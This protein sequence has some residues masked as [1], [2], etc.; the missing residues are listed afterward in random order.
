MMRKVI[1]G[2]VVSRN[3]SPGLMSVMALMPAHAAT[4]PM[5]VP[6]SAGHGESCRPHLTGRGACALPNATPSNQ[7]PRQN[8]S[9]RVFD[10]PIGQWRADHTQMSAIIDESA[11]L[12]GFRFHQPPRM[13]ADEGE[14]AGRRFIR[15][16]GDDS[17]RLRAGESG[18]LGRVHKPL[19][20][21]S[22]RVS[23]SPIGTDLLS[24]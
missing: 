17:C 16:I 2:T 13:R 21:V 14:E 7:Y 5:V 9:V 8:S 1:I 4:N 22:D 24:K 11:A 12:G 15:G 20:G 19:I 23:G 10:R 3:G 18:S 6:R